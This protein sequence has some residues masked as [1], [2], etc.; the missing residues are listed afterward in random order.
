MTPST[1]HTQT[2]ER[3]TLASQTLVRE[4]SRQ[5]RSTSVSNQSFPS[6]FRL[7]NLS[8][9][10][11]LSRRCRTGGNC[12]FGM[13]GGEAAIGALSDFRSTRSDW[14]SCSARATNATNLIMGLNPTTPTTPKLQ[15]LPVLLS[16]LQSTLRGR[17]VEHSEAVARAAWG[18][19][20]EYAQWSAIGQQF[21]LDNVQELAKLD[22]Q[23]VDEHIYA[24]Q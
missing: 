3:L 1:D 22:D 7:L 24:V 23:H 13:S 20:Y 6:M 11:P 16:H 4:L 19:A 18:I 10:H 9:C 5:T 21:K 15:P 12:S 14:T 17:A 2:S 8:H